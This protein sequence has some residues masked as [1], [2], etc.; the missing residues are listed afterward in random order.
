VSGARR[1]PPLTMPLR[2]YDVTQADF[3]LME[4]L[5][6]GGQGSVRRAVRR[7]DGRQ[8]VV[9]TVDVAKLSPFDKALQRNE[10]KVCVCVCE[11]VCVCARA[12]GWV[13]ACVLGGTRESVH[14]FL[15]VWRTAACMGR[16]AAGFAALGH[17]R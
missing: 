15:C 14:V 9:K 10:A 12:R 13:Y 8:F 3:E 4:P 17:S 6:S 5:G 7:A 1:V 16:V 11:C 2:P